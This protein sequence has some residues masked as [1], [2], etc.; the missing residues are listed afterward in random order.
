LKYVT[1]FLIGYSFGIALA[2]AIPDPFS[3]NPERLLISLS[4]AGTRTWCANIKKPPR[5]FASWRR[6]RAKLSFGSRGKWK[7]VLDD[8][9]WIFPRKG[10]AW[11]VPCCC[12]LG[13]G[14]A[15][16]ICETTECEGR[17]PYP[18]I[19]TAWSRNLPNA[20]FGGTCVFAYRR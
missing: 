12:V 10:C 14:G 6:S 20:T 2:P 3:P 1:G 15:G 16:E 17:A 5:G 18:C 9:C 4:R 11:T 19:G 7:G 8:K 13:A